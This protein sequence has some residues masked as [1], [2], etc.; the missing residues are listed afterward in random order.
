[1]A[2]HSNEQFVVQNNKIFDL[3]IGKNSVNFIGNRLTSLVVKHLMNF[4]FLSTKLPTCSVNIFKV[5][6]EKVLNDWYKR[7]SGLTC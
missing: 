2:S 7:D 3:T 5:H 4:N 6:V 1:M